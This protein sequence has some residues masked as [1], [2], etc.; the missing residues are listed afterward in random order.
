M[1]DEEF[2]NKILGIFVCFMYTFIALFVLFVV[3]INNVEAATRMFGWNSSGTTN[4]CDNTNFCN[5]GR[6]SG[7]EI[8]QSINI[9]PSTNVVIRFEVNS[10]LVYNDNIVL[11]IDNPIG[12]YL[13]NATAT[14]N[15][16]QRCINNAFNQSVQGDVVRRKSYQIN[17]TCNLE[18]IQSS[19]D[20]LL[21]DFNI[22]NATTNLLYVNE[23]MA[24]DSNFTINSN[25]STDS[26]NSAINSSSS[27]IIN[28]D[29]KNTQDIIDSITGGELEDNSQPDDSKINDYQDSEGNLIDK[30]KLNNINNIEISLDS[31]S[32]TFIWNLVDKILNTHTL[33]FGLIITMLSLGIIKLVLNR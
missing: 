7:F 23:I 30:D 11:N 6:A 1:S 22:P 10:D 14:T 21:L 29:N 32:N 12:I 13:S 25:V 24:W 3:G 16:T 27:N 15:I 17:Y 2:S 20:K 18:N 5:F 31:N 8:Q 19:Y 26:I 9:S 33:I 28:N 4:I